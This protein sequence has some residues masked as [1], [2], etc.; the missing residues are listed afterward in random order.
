MT[1]SAAP[2]L[3]E[4]ESLVAVRPLRCLK[5]RT[6]H[7]RLLG[8]ISDLKQLSFMLEAEPEN[9]EEIEKEV[10]LVLESMRESIER[11]SEAEK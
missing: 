4:G 6:R 1:L 2:I 10:L 8:S 3:G 11:V 9:R 7:G 5:S